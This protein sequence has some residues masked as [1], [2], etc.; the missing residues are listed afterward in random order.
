MKTIQLASIAL[1][2][3]SFTALADARPAR[4]KPRAVAS[5]AVEQSPI[6]LSKDIKVTGEFGKDFTLGLRR[7]TEVAVAE[8]D[9]G[10]ARTVTE[11]A[12]GKVVRERS[13][14][15]EYCWLRVPA[16]K[17]TAS[18]AVL[19]LMIEASGSVAGASLEGE[20]PAGV[21]K[22]IE[23]AAAKWTFPAEDEGCEIE[24][25]LSFNAKTDVH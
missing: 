4:S 10:P 19:K 14:E 7:A 8:T 11:S 12:V 18:S 22:C 2:L 3:T 15:L 6:V 5:A 9:K 16:A 21:T 25:G 1:A 24:H 13:E 23:A 17:R 20:V